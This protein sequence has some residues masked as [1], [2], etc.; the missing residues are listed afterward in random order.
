MCGASE[1]EPLEGRTLAMQSNDRV[2]TSFRGHLDFEPATSG[3]SSSY[4]SGLSG[5][6]PGNPMPMLVRMCA[7]EV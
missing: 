1:P 7:R 4:R 6:P 5:M 2:R 3:M